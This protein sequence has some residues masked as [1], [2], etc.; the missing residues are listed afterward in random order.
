[1][2]KIVL[3][4]SGMSCSA[5]SN[6]LE[7]YLSKQDGISLASV[8]LVMANASIEYDEEKLTVKDLER[9]IKEAGFKSTG[10]FDITKSNEKV[11]YTDTI[12]FGVLVLVMMYFSMGHMIGLPNFKI[13]DHHTSPI[14]YA[15][16]QLVLVIPF[17]VYGFDILKGGIKALFHLVPDM[18]TLITL[19]VISGFTYSF[20]KFILFV[21]GVI[22]SYGS[23]YFESCTMV[24]FFVKLGRKIDK[25]GKESTKSALKSLV[26]ITPDFAVLKVNGEEKKVTIDEVKPG[27]TVVC[28]AGEKFA[29][30]GKII[31]GSAHVD[32]SFITG[33]S[34]PQMRKEGEN[35]LAGS[36]NY[37]GYIEYEAK[38]IGK[39]STVSEIVRLVSE[40]SNTKMPIA[41]TADKICGIFVPTVMG[42]ALLG[43]IIYLICGA[44]FSESLNV[45]ITVLVTACPCA[46]GLATPLAVVVGEGLCAERGILCKDG[47][48][49]EIA[50]K[51]DT[52]FFDKT[53]T[54]TTGKP[55]IVEVENASGM[56][57]DELVK[58]CA[59]VE[60]FSS[61]P[62]ANAF[63]L[64][65]KDDYFL[66][67][68][69]FKNYSGFGI[70]ADI[71]G[72]TY[73]LGKGAF[74]AEYA[75]IK[76]LPE[77]SKNAVYT[78][79]CVAENSKYLGR[80]YVADAL[81]P[82]A[83][84]LIVRLN[85]LGVEPVM[86]T[87]DN[88]AAAKEILKDIDIKR[89]YSGVLPKEKSDYILKEKEAGKIT[90][91]CGDGIND[92][93]ALAVADVGIAV[94]NGT[95]VAV[96]CAE[97]TLM[98]DDLMKITE[99][100]KISKN[101]L[102]CIRMNLFWAFIYNVLMIPIALG[103]LKWAGITL[104]PMFASLAMVLSSLT[105]IANTLLL[106]RK[107]LK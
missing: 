95:D 56:T 47:K 16:E 66:P 101:T 31:S 24:I 105:V 79:I 96:D 94:K 89:Y 7:K 72:K 78:E 106:K 65:K 91:M 29:V 35:V 64:S 41:A 13:F 104:N 17:L 36:I 3:G 9:F 80:I 59:S 23:L 1:M 52:L 32:E 53:G 12:I 5:C 42:I 57:D 100:I 87:G 73:Y 88:E 40:A 60:K 74:I 69:N 77:K 15:A 43:F 97:V 14:G 55:V 84:E 54:L 39:N 46:L 45:F 70:S 76:D 68:E 25:S 34:K 92:S 10:L 81:K 27:D 4:I 67:A 93:P 2:K 63:K 82:D 22:P 99:F 44:G 33:E 37:D 18:N 103:A 71:N 21:C 6:G 86:L 28:K 75:G 8:N 107:S 19:G 98:T 49:L 90:A 26:T 38:N 20:V 30:D 51:I 83:K 58:I 85:K 102:K 62:I 48:T 61:H 50:D 11:T